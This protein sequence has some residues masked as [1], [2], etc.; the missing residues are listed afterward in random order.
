MVCANDLESVHST[1]AR[2]RIK[3]DSP[4]RSL[5]DDRY[6]VVCRG[7]YEVYML[8]GTRD[9]SSAVNALGTRLLIETHKMPLPP[10]DGPR[11]SP[12]AMCPRGSV[13]FYAVG[14]GK[15]MKLTPTSLYE[16]LRLVE[17]EPQNKAYVALHTRYAEHTDR[18]WTAM[19]RA[20]PDDPD[21]AARVSKEY[22]GHSAYWLVNS[23]AVYH[24]L[25][26]S[27]RWNGLYAL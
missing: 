18:N 5:R 3:T 4:L 24:S 27:Y 14:R 26:R 11:E 17:E 7:K 25:S 13:L 20:L 23:A 1:L 16:Q 12:L 9:A 6:C 8:F 2:H 19:Y 22:G 10:T 15:M 21:L